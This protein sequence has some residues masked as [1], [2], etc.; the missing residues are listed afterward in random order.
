M[1]GADA[2][3]ANPNGFVRACADGGGEAAVGHVSV[4]RGFLFIRATKSF[5]IDYTSLLYSRQT[6]V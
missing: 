4:D 6:S 2:I 5:L 3:P 1:I